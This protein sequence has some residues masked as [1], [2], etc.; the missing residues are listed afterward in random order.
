LRADEFH[1]DRGTAIL[2]LSGH[3]QMTLIGAKK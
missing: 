1:A 2:T 3:V